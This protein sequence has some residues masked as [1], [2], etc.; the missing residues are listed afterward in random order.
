MHGSTLTSRFSRL[1][2]KNEAVSVSNSIVYLLNMNFH[3]QIEN[4]PKVASANKQKREKRG[5]KLKKNDQD[6]AYMF[7]FLLERTKKLSG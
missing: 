6:N 2:Q 1:T 4:L 7:F 3:C 5:Q